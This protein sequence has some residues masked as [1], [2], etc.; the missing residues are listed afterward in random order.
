MKAVCID[1]FG[2]IDKLHVQDVPTPKPIKNEVQI[3]IAYT[4]VNPVDWKIREGYLR[5]ILPHAF[6]LIPG[7]DAA[8]LVSAVGPD[9]EDFKVGDEV[10]AYCRKPT[11]QWGTY[12]EYIC[13]AEEFVSIKPQKLSLAESA[14]IPLVALTAWQALFDFADLM[15]GQSILI[16]AGAGGVGSLAIQFAKYAGAQVVTTASAA[17]HAYVHD[18]GADDVIDYQTEDVYERVK[19]DSPD[20]MDMVFDCAGGAALKSGYDLVR[21]G[22]Y[23]ASI[24]EPVNKELADE[25][26]IHVASIFVRPSG[27]ELEEIARLLDR[28]EVRVPH[29]EVMSLKD[30]VSAQEK[31][32]LGHKRG[33]IVLKISDESVT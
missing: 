24:V 31:S 10:Y 23:L 1:A 11:V 30:A 4:S 28:G 29:I 27:R 18:L 9:V 7:W 22:G 6:P 16:H 19:K 8:G 5:D 25:K 3:K 32:R 20:G 26:G 13:L 33:K 14:A 2:G 21:P 15:S 17:N 12:A